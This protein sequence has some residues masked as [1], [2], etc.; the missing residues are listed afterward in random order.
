MKT[1]DKAKIK[2][3]RPPILTG[4]TQ[5]L[6]SAL[7]K[8]LKL[9][10]L[11]YWVSTGGSICQNDVIAMSRLLGPAKKQSKV[12]LFLKSDG[13]NPEAALRFVHLL[14]QKFDRIMLLAPFECASAATMVALGANEIHMGP[15]SYLTAVDSSLKHDLSPVDHHNCLVS[16]SQDEVMRILRLWKEQKCGDNPFP[17][18]YKYLHPLVLGALDRSSSLSMRICQELLSYHVRNRAKALKISRA[19]NYDY[20]SHSYPITIREA[21]KL[22]L[23]VHDL[24][25]EVDA[26]LR[27]LSQTYS[28]MAHA[29]NTDYD[30][31]N[32]HNGEICNILELVG[33]QIFYQVDKDWHYRNEE[34]RWI[35]MNDQSG[36]YLCT[37]RNQKW[38]PEKIFIR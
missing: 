36:W 22:G 3:Q 34:K 16:V 29:K 33:R 9:P 19:L 27:D 6:V 21:R 13:G 11:V 7:Q 38:I 4:K 5:K 30:T 23:N 15:T 1:T 17:E 35:P 18:V 37:E 25:P 2:I 24:N 28:E 8:E 32:Y 14:R 31:Q 26:L 12:A 20:P 10:V